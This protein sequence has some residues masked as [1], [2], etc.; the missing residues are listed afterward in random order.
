[1]ECTRLLNE[2]AQARQTLLKPSKRKAYDEMLAREGKRTAS[3]D[4]ITGQAPLAKNVFEEMDEEGEAARRFEPD[5]VRPRSLKKS[6]N[7]WILPVA[8][9]GGVAVLI[10]A[11]IVGYKL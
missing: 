11:S 4:A 1:A 8:I 9:G 2:I 3:S 7:V 5:M 6:G 10:I